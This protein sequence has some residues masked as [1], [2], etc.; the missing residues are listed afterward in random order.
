MNKYIFNKIS[1]F[2]SGIG[3]PDWELPAI[4]IIS[5]KSTKVDTFLLVTNA[6]VLIP[7]QQV[8]VAKLLKISL[9]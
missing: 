8:M 5:Y 9:V 2:V 1:R 7:I 4:K 6:T 3:I